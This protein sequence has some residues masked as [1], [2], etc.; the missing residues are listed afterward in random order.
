MK[1]RLAVAVLLAVMLVAVLSPAVYAGKEDI[2]RTF[3]IVVTPM[4]KEDIPRTFGFP[5]YTPLG[6]EDIPRTFSLPT[7]VVF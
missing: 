3:N 1:K 6:K 4:G 2:P 7:P 5:G